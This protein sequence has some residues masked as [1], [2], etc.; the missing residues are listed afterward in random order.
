MGKSAELREEVRKS[1]FPFIKARGFIQE[2]SGSPLFMSFRKKGEDRTYLVDIHWDKRY[3]PRFV[4]EFGHCDNDG[5]DFGGVHIGAEKVSQGQLQH[6]GRIYAKRG[7]KFWSP[8]DWFRQDVPLL[9]RLFLFKALYPASEVVEQL[10]TN[11]VELETFW[12]SGQ[13]GPHLD[14]RYY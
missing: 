7:N 9:K 5:V 6:R 8:G 3:H 10:R 11:F 13:A 14:V 12:Q 2:K 1:F 4:V